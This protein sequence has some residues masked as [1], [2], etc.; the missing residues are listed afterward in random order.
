[1][2]SIDNTKATGCGRAQQADAC[3]GSAQAL[4]HNEKRLLE[5]A[6]EMAA[7]KE[8]VESEH[9]SRAIKTAL[10]NTPLDAVCVLDADGRV[11]DLNEVAALRCGKPRTAIAGQ[12]I[13]DLLPPHVV[14]FRKGRID[15]V[16]ASGNPVRFEDEREGLWNDSIV[17]PI[18]H[19][20]GRVVSVVVVAHDITECKQVEHEL[21]RSKKLLEN[22]QRMAKVG[23]WDVDLS[24]KETQWSEELYRI[25]GYAAGEIEPTVGFFAEHIHPD[26]LEQFLNRSKKH[27][28]GDYGLL[29][30]QAEY[31]LIARDG[32]LKWVLGNTEAEYDYEGNV[33]R[34]FGTVQDITDRRRMEEALRESE[35]KFRC[36]FLESGEGIVLC[37][38][39]WRIIGWNKAIERIT[40]CPESQFIN[41]DASDMICEFFPQKYRT[42]E[43]HDMFRQRLAAFLLDTD[44][45]TGEFTMPGE[46][47]ADRIFSYNVFKIPLGS[48]FMYGTIIRDITDRKLVEVEREKLIAELTDALAQIKTLKG[49]LPICSTCKKIRD[50][51]GY[52]NTLEKYI[53][54]HSEAEFTH[55]ICPDCIRRFFPEACEKDGPCNDDA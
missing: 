1:M 12:I 53:M 16:F 32:S 39:Q 5:L 18:H 15:G 45:V 37:D 8:T 47:S 26:D 33:S 23:N 22:A 29:G 30:T 21:R 52:W 4:Q 34:I 43:L 7:H 35:E 38:K 27:G 48:S 42:P 24:P 6:Q 17:Y 46:D 13:W 41:R 28:V 11:L 10:L 50:D 25:L 2:Q 20:D 31:R 55:G 40:G 9:N 54:E 51:M 36:L 19:T 3:G 49:L 14:R 44:S